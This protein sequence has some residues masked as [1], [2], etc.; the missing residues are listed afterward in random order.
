MSERIQQVTKS[1]RRRGATSAHRAGLAAGV[2]AAA[3][4][5]GST[6]PASA[7]V[8]PSV[9]PGHQTSNTV[10]HGPVCK[11]SSYKPDLHVSDLSLDGQGNMSVILQNFGQGPAKGPFNVVVGITSGNLFRQL[12]IAVPASKTFLGYGCGGSER[13]AHRVTGIPHAPGYIEVLV[14]SDGM[15]TESN[16]QNNHYRL[17]CTTS[18]RVKIDCTRYN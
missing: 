4:L 14:D 13:L 3:A 9:G 7:K 16:E 12:T 1:E 6:V 8:D 10:G 17:T 15:V 5:L 11:N 2:L 18:L